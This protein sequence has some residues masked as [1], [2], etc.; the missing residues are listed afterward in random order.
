MRGQLFVL[1]APSGTGKTT[2]IQSMLAGGLAN[3]GDLAFSVSHTTRHRRDGE[4]DGRDYHFVDHETFQEMIAGDHFLEWA[5][6]HNNYYG[7]ARDEVEPRLE[8]GLDVIMDIDVQGAQRMLQRGDEAVGIFVMPPSYDDLRDRLK[9]RR[10]DEPGAIEKRL[11]V[12]AWEVR[13][14]RQYDYV[15]INDDARVASERLASIIL[16][17]R[18]RTERMQERSDAILRDFQSASAL[19]TDSA[20]HEADPAASAD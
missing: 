12:S 5:E 7:T 1:S 19:P 3:F 8:A 20:P 6:V 10:L 13:R 9:G 11:A 18:H 17:H 15:I 4:V 16:A 14:Y 2:L